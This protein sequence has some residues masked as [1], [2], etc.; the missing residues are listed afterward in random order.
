MF[1]II[2]IEED[3]LFSTQYDAVLCCS[4]YEQRA[5]FL[6][7]QLLKRKAYGDSKR[8]LISFNDFLD[9]PERTANDGFFERFGF[10]KFCE[11][12]QVYGNI[13]ERLVQLCSEKDGTF[14][15]LVD[16]SAMRRTIYS[17]IIY[18]MKALK[19]RINLEV[20]FS[21][22]VGVP[23]GSHRPKVISDYLL[24]PGFEGNTD[25]QRE[26][27]AIYCLGFEP[28]IL[29]SIHEW[30]EP[31][32]SI[33]FYAEPGMGPRSG[34]RCLQLNKRFLEESDCPAYPAP[35]WSVRHFVRLFV[36]ATKHAIIDRD[37]MVFSCGPK[38]FVLAT[39]LGSSHLLSPSHVYARGVESQAVDSR[40]TGKI[41][42]TRVVVALDRG[43]L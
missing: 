29:R 5:R 38:P 18:L 22:S 1:D 6:P 41:V 35:L 24:L 11:N 31:S 30:I 8:L 39:L 9:H 36:E 10:I 34:S 13:S 2:D 37:V 40:S 12:W 23:S 33:A 25:S 7:K 19:N 32:A 21:Y 43:L 3:T 15:L 28:I 14:R 20:T 42:A 4:G 27:F 16:Y 17:E 26:K